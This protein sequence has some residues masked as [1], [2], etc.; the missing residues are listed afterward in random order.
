MDHVLKASIQNYIA[1]TQNVAK[2]KK[3]HYLLTTLHQNSVIWNDINQG[4]PVHGR[5]TSYYSIKLSAI[6]ISQ[7][8]HEILRNISTEN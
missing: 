2:K 3:S 6:T 4:V 1:S 7:L 8:S 5:F